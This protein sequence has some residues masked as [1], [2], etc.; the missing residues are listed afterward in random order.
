MQAVGCSVVQK[1]REH[2]GTLCVVQTMRN[3]IAGALC[4]VTRAQR[5]PCGERPGTLASARGGHEAATG[6][7]GRHCGE[8]PETAGNAR[9]GRVATKGARDRP[10]THHQEIRPTSGAD[11]RRPR[12]P[13]WRPP[14][15]RVPAFPA[16]ARRPRALWGAG[17]GR[18]R[19]R[20]RRSPRR[21]SGRQNANPVV[22]GNASG[23]SRSPGRVP[24]P[25]PEKNGPCARKKPT[26]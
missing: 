11:T 26:V 15:E 2:A 19:K 8:S 9:T 6:A 7:R 21:H 3:N 12:E 25:V 14:K 1:C 18:T 16:T 20:L 10:R 22:W 23:P 5:C 24:E 4:A 13:T 17:V